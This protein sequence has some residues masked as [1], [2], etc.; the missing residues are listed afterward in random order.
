MHLVT[1]LTVEISLVK[2]YNFTSS[3]P[4][5]AFVIMT[6]LYVIGQYYILEFVTKK[7]EEA[8]VRKVFQLTIQKV[9]K[10]IQYVLSIALVLLFLQMILTS[11]YYSALLAVVTTISY[12]LAIFMLGLFSKRF[13]SWFRLKRNVIVLFYGLASGALCINAI[14][15][16]TF[17]YGPFLNLPNEIKPNYQVMYY[18]PWLGRLFEFCV[19]SFLD[20]IVYT[21]LA[22][23]GVASK[24]IF[25]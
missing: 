6:A 25:S 9:V 7:L 18:T 20:H 10:V 4:V 21:N 14:L 8:G 11:Y 13:I 1:G 23:H 15:T 2:T 12:A 17:V 22:C 24:F 3:A 5:S 16:L 19:H